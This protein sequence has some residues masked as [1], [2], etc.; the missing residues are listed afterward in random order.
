ML[1]PAERLRV[2]I[3]EQPFYIGASRQLTITVSI[4]VACFPA[5]VDNAEILVAAADAGLYAAK[6]SG[7]NKVCVYSSTAIN[8]GNQ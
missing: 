4:G 5:D 3:E 1:I 7:R 8:S 6:E 2:A